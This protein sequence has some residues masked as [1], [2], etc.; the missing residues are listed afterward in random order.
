MFALLIV[1]ANTGVLTGYRRDATVRSVGVGW[2]ELAGAIEAVRVRTGA[3]LRAGARLRH[4]RMARLLSAEG[5][6]RGA[7]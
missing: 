2:R 3:D 4:H 1:Q 7:A 6:L 5:H